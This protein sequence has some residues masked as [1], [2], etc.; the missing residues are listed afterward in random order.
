MNETNLNFG[1]SVNTVTKNTNDDTV[2]TRLKQGSLVLKSQKFT[3]FLSF[4]ITILMGLS[5]E[6]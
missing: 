3:N 5:H 1:L 6:K 2:S 4:Y